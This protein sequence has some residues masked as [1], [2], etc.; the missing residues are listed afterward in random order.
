MWQINSP[1]GW[2]SLYTNRRFNTECNIRLSSQV[3]QANTEAPRTD[4]SCLSSLCSL[5]SLHADLSCYG[6]V[7]RAVPG[8]ATR[9]SNKLTRRI[10]FLKTVSCCL[11]CCGNVCLGSIVQQCGYNL[12]LFGVIFCLYFGDVLL[13]CSVLT[14][15]IKP[16]KQTLL[17]SRSVG[18]NREI[19]RVESPCPAAPSLLAVV[20]V[21]SS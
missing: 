5:W 8:S 21:I 1:V 9:C 2:F 17:S 20:S 10:F 14:L 4:C 18:T 13:C 15:L 16:E 3:E 12:F 11:F 19:Q 7:L 6:N